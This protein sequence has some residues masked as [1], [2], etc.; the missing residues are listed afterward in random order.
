M[1]GLITERHFEVAERMF[2]GIGAFYT[3]LAQ[4]PLTFLELVWEYTV[5]GDR[6]P[7]CDCDESPYTGD[8]RPSR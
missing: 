3:A 4:K 6:F 2:P 8:S 1:R 5:H 7:V